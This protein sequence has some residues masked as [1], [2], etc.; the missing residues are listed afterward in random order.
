MP[1]DKYCDEH[2]THFCR[3]HESVAVLTQPEPE[4]GS[5]KFIADL[6]LA[7][8]QER[9]KLGADRYGAYLQTDNG[10]DHLIDA[11]QEAIDLCLYLRAEIE[12]R[13]NE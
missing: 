8:I 10:R 7:D 9:S 2:K 1:S 4:W 6:V 13:N 12:K 11:Y 5:G 3:K